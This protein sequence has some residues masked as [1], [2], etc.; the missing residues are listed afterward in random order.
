MSEKKHP[1]V[2]PS[3]YD[4]ARAWITECYVI[5]A[6]TADAETDCLDDAAWDLADEIQNA[7]ESWLGDAE[8]SGRLRLLRGPE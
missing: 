5:N 1:S 4:L 3:I 6:D 8:G 2:D 7:I